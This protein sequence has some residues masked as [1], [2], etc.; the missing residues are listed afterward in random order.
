M[1]V[2]PPPPG[3]SGACC[4]ALASALGGGKVSFPSSAPYAA[5]LS[6]YFALQESEL[7]PRC[8]VFPETTGDVADAVKML[9]SGGE[10]SDGHQKPACAFAIRSGGHATT[11]G[12]ANVEDGVTLD[13]SKLNQIKVHE[14]NQ[15][16]LVGVGNTWGDVYSILDPLGLSVAGGRAAQVGVG[17]LTTGG[18]VSYFSPRYG[19]TCDTVVDFE[20]VLADGSIVH[21]NKDEHPDLLYA[22]RGG[23]NNFGVV[24]QVELEAF[25]QGPV[26]GGVVHYG[27]DT[28]ETQ[29]KEAYELTNSAEGYDEYASLIMSFTLA[30]GAGSVVSNSI[31]YTKEEENPAVFKPLMDI[32]SKQSTM[33]IKPMAEMA[34]EQGAFSVDGKRELMVETTYR[35]TPPILDATFLHWNESLSA[36]ED[37]PGLVWSLS[38]EPLPPA[39][40]AKHAA[41]NALGIPGT[42]G[43]LMIVLLSATWTDEA[44]DARVEKASRELFRAIEDDANRMG[45]YSPYIYLNYAAPW[46]DPISSYGGKNVGKLHKVSKE[47]DPKGIFQ[48]QVAGFKLRRPNP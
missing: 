36:V 23:S 1:N 9:T 16:V 21:A 27:V 13:L 30:A 33:K 48:S 38:L 42:A 18:G 20:V 34:K 5:S 35:T 32:P 28:I 39:I 8:I 14:S 4:A 12:T 6:S 2:N 41:E 25:E 40:Y 11:P 44:D 29:L 15:T 26:W 3:D 43:S 31:V 19:W 47:V 46:Q 10:P 7:H 24:T 17:G 37:V 22:L 45:V